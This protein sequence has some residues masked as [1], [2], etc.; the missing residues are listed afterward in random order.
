MYPIPPNEHL[1]ETKVCKQCSVSFPITDKD[2]EFY[3]KVSPTFWGKKYSIPAPTLCPDCRQQRRLSFRNERKLYKRECD[4]TE[5]EIISIYSPDK[6][7]T[8]YHQDYW[9]SDKWNPMDYGGEFDFSRRFFEQFRELSKVVPRLG[10]CNGNSCENCDY[11]NQIYTCNSCYLIFS[12]QND[13]NCAYG[14]RLIDSSDCIDCLLITQ[15]SHCYES[16]DISGSTLCF[17]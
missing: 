2:M 13:E 4:V 11:T 17:F 6:P 12:C 7:Y 10:L 8:V 9:W 15:S 14:K 3:K 1:V 16:I 5:K